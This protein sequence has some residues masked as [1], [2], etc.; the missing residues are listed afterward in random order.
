MGPVD[1][2][3]IVRDLDIPVPAEV[4]VGITTGDDAGVYRIAPDLNLVL[5][6]DFITPPCDD[7]HLFGRIAAANALSDVYAM[8]GTPKAALNLCCFPTRGITQPTLTEILRGGLDTLTK[9]G[10]A[11]IGGHTVRDEELKYGLSVTGIV[12]DADI[13]TNAA[14]RVG[15]L[16]ILTKPLGTGIVVTGLRGGLITEVEARP[17]LEAM[18]ELN[19]TACAVMLAFGGVHGVTDITGFGL[20]GHA[21]EMAQASRVGLR[22]MESRIPRWPLCDSLVARGVKSAVK[23][24]GNEPLETKVRVDARIDAAR[25]MLFFDPQTSGGLLMSVDPGQAEPMLRRL[26]DAGLKD[27]AICGEVMAAEVPHIEVLP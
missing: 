2:S 11:L 27:A 4:L 12:R 22:F 20:A 6:A 14:A 13:K 3:A 25:Q 17:V 23:L 9:A 7:P 10:V 8:G 26:E 24:T 5:T 16:L 18:A 15:D 1:L 19:H 21:W